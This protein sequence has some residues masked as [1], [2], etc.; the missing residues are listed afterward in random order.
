MQ[1]VPGLTAP[2]CQRLNLAYDEALSDFAGNVNYSR[3]VQ[4][5]FPHV[6]ELPAGGVRVRFRAERGRAVQVDPIRPTLKAPGTRLL[7]LN[8]FQVLLSNSTCAATA[9]MRATQLR[10]V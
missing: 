10:S 9:R 4:C 8:R 2:G 5:R 3:Y 6:T 7:I 1:V